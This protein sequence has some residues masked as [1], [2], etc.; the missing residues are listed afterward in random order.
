MALDEDLHVAGP[1]LV[2]VGVDDGVGDRLRD[3]QRDRVGIDGSLLARVGLHLAAGEAHLVGL[4]REAAGEYRRGHVRHAVPRSEGPQTE[5]ARL[6]A[7]ALHAGAHRSGARRPTPVACSM[8]AA[9]RRRPSSPRWRPTSCRPTG[10]PSGVKPAGSDERRVRGDRDPRARA[11]P[12]EVGAHRRSPAI[13]VDPFLL[14]GE[15]RHLADGQRQRVVALE[16]RAHALVHLGLQPERPSDVGAGQRAARRACSSGWSPS[17]GRRSDSS[18]GAEG[19][20]VADAAQR[21]RRR[22]RPP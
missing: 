16:Q 12:L 8:A 20:R 13:S 15:R 18:N 17:A 21:P 11:H 2:D 3:G 6:G 4:S 19:L 9:R 7:I 1:G 22:R 5:D 14:D 10:S